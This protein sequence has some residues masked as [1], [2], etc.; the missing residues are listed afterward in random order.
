MLE[1][2][3]WSK[4]I[5]L[6][7]AVKAFRNSSAIFDRITGLISSLS[8]YPAKYLAPVNYYNLSSNP[9]RIIK[10]DRHDLA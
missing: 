8:C 9:E 7:F 5:E 6:G 1:N 3:C 10:G 4:H 2:Y